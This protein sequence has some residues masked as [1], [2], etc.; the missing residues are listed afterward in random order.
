MA[1]H[2]SHY[3]LWKALMHGQALGVATEKSLLDIAK[4][5]WYDG[6]EG[7]NTDCQRRRIMEFIALFVLGVAYGV[8]IELYVDLVRYR[9][10]NFK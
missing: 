6:Y 4:F 5:W 8:W 10:A 9:R 2:L 1:D 3:L 7:F